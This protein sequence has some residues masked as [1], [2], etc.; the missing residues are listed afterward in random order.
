MRRATE[1]E[2]EI[3]FRDFVLGTRARLVKFA[4]FLTGDIGI[5][6]DL[7]QHAHAKIYARWP[8]LQ[9]GNP[10]AYARRCIIN[11][12]TDRWRRGSSKEQPLDH[13]V[14]P[15]DSFSISA[16]NA[17]RDVVMRALRRLTK[18]ERTIIALKYYCD[19]SNDQIARDLGIATAT[20]RTTV[21]RALVKLREDHDLTRERVE[22]N[23]RRA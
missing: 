19:L 22:E 3:E 20:V 17:E 18:R 14:D 16:V 23:E 12:H 15:A 5:A 13:T 2:A 7:V 6:E 21:F 9:S 10:E 11:A 4:E 8:K 1:A